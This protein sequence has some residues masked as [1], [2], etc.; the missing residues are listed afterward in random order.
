MTASIVPVAFF[1]SAKE[2]AGVLSDRIKLAR[3]TV[4]ELRRWLTDIE[5]EERQAERH[6]K[7]REEDLRKILPQIGYTIDA[8]EP[9]DAIVVQMPKHGKWPSA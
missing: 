9:R 2:E 7:R 8:D 1:S 4:D 3:V 6:I 5:T